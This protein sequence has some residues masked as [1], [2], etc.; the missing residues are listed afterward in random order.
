M[1]GTVKVL[2]ID[3]NPMIL[4]MLSQAL[5]KFAELETTTDSAEGLL[6]IVEAPPDLLITDYQMPGMDGRQ[7]VEKLKD[8]AATARLPIILMATKAD[9]NEKLKVVED[10]IEDFLEKPFF[11][12]EATARIKRIIDRIA[13]EKMAREAPG[14]GTLRGTLQ[15]MN[16]IDLLQ[17]LELSRKTCR[18]TLTSGDDRCQLFFTEGQ[19]NHGVY[20]ALSGDESVYKVLTWQDGNFQIDFTSSSTEQTITRS[21]QGLLMEG[22]RLLDEANRDASE[23]NVLDA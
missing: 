19:I 8:R 18:L 20:G 23:D 12:K 11:V 4:G 6:K 16:V 22:L 10:K 5:G 15:Q 7:L 9:Q 14:D 17:S 1:A 3:D 21:T 2:L 13:L